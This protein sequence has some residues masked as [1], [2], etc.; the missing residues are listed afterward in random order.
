MDTENRWMVARG[1]GRGW[2]QVREGGQKVQIS[3][4]KKK[5]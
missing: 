3:Q 1:G 5:V 4:K 2:G